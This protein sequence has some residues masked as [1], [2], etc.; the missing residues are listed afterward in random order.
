MRRSE[1]LHA[2]KQELTDDQDLVLLDDQAELSRCS[3]DAYEYSPVLIPRL[4]G[5]RAELVARP[6]TVEAVERLTA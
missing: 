2:L 1:A 5:C 3:R 4:S 6:R